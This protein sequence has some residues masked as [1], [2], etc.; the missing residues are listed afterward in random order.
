VD[1]RTAFEGVAGRNTATRPLRTVEREEEESR[2][3]RRE[4]KDLKEQ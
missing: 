2:N 3:G 1:R 4:W